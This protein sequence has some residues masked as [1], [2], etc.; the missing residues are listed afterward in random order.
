MKYAG[1]KLKPSKCK[2]LQSE[3]TYLGFK[4]TGNIVRTDEAKTACISSWQFPKNISELR[5]LIGFFS[6]YRM[7]L[8]NF[9]SRIEPLNEMLRKNEAIVPTKRRL[10]AFQDLKSALL[11]APVL[12]IYRPDGEIVI[13]VDTSLTACGAICSQFQDNVLRPLFFASQIRTESMRLSQRNVGTDICL[14]NSVRTS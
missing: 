11:N 4:V 2:L 5:S 12:G 8:Q 10:D 13:D 3:V 14:K 9:A 1:L 7:F 6:Y